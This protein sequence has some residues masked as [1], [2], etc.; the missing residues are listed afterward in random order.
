MVTLA[1]ARVPWHTDMMLHNAD[2]LEDHPGEAPLPPSPS[3]MC[4]GSTTSTV[5]PAQG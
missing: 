5:A 3:T 1:R 2:I 4:P